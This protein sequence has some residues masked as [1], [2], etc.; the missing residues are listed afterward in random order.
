MYNKNRLKGVILEIRKA[1]IQDL[2]S[3]QN[4]NNKLFNLELE[5]YDNDLKAGWPLT[6]DGKKYFNDLIMNNIVFV[7]TDNNK[8]IGYIAGRINQ[9]SGYTINKSAELEN[10]Y[11][12]EDFRKHGIGAKL[13]NEFKNVCENQSVKSI[14]VI[15]SYKNEVAISFYK[16]HLFNNKDVVLTCDIKG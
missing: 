4:L 13:I 15:A 3:I 14:K 12:D 7:A 5:N 11:I 16:K 10:M 8:V 2:E 1:N 9:A 6:H